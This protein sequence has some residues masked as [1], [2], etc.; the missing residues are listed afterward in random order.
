MLRI[1]LCF[2]YKLENKMNIKYDVVV[3]FSWEDE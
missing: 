2:K 3:Q 1:V